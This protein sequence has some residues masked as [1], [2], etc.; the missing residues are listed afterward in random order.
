MY[1]DFII[2]HYINHAMPVLVYHTFSWPQ[3]TVQ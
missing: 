1:A 2:V 3:C